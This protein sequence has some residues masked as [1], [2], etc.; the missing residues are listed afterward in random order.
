MDQKKKPKDTELS[1]EERTRRNQV[2]RGCC[3]V[4]RLLTLGTFKG[5]DAQKVVDS[6]KFLMEVIEAHDY[7]TDRSLR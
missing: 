6:M 7:E 3:E 2:I 4:K 1:L 5:D